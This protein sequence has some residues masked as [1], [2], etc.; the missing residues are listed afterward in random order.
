MK[1]LLLTDNFYPETNAAAS[2]TYERACY[3]VKAGHQ[4]TVLTSAPNFPQG[5]VY[6]GYKNKWYQRET[7]DG[8]DVVRVKTFMVPNEGAFLRTIDF[9]SYM[10]MAFTVGLF[11][12][13]ADVV[14]AS[15]PQFFTAVAGWGVA[16]LKRK[17]FAFELADLWPAS[18]HAV[19]AV[20][21]GLGLRL[22]EKL[23]LFLYRRAK[24]IVA[25]TQ[26]FKKDLVS[27]GIKTKKIHVVPNGVDLERFKPEPASPTLV[28]KYDLANELV[29]GYLGNHGP[30]Q[31]LSNIIE[32]AECLESLEV[33][34]LLVGDGAEKKHLVKSVKDKKLSNVQFIASQPK[35][36]MPQ[37]WALCNIA[38]VHLKN[39]PVF[40]TVI[41]SKLFEAMAMG[42]PILL[43]SPEGEAADII[44]DEQVGWWVPA[45]QPEALADKVR[46]I[47]SCPDE[48]D[49]YTGNSLK[50]AASHSREQQACDMMTALQAVFKD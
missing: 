6:K 19:G 11:Q 7:L 15:S 12:K 47:L 35:A 42:L 5:K 25:L 16:A 50:A 26:A 23:E 37:Y 44:R 17:P 8:I 10:V 36:N 38:L 32:A 31:N 43:V 49:Q 4:V 24:V 34:F 48:I 33:Q 45:G 39:D 18:I 14:V 2:R 28:S 41:P 20:K 27:R 22:I 30:A 9:L 1:I 13:K 29:L 3:W 21:P 46:Y 40:G